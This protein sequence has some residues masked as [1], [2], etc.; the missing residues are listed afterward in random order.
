MQLGIEYTLKVVKLEDDGVG[1]YRGF[2]KD[3][4]KSGETNF[5]LDLNLKVLE[6]FLIQ[7]QQV[8]LMTEKYAY[9]IT[10][11]DMHTTNLIAYQHAGCFIT[12][13]SILGNL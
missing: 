9:F 6:E 10:N 13:V 5:I 11:L 7:A 12:G 3:I 2:L 8:G 1:D 4:K